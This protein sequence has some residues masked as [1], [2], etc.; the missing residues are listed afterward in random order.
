MTKDYY[1]KYCGDF[2]AALSFL[3]SGVCSKS[4]NRRHQLYMGSRRGREGMDEKG[5]FHGR[6]HHYHCKYCGH[7]HVTISELTRM[8]CTKSPNGYH[9]PYEGKDMPVYICKYC[10]SFSRT[11]KRLTRG[12]CSV[13]PNGYHQPEE[14]DHEENT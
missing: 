13:S 12:S 2:H 5:K 10:A 6:N 8:P 11:I 1:C 14:I 3:L 4:P 7:P 9:Q